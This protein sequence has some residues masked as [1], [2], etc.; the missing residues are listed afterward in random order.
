MVAVSAASGNAAGDEVSLRLP[1]SAGPHAVPNLHNNKWCDY[2]RCNR[3]ACCLA[4][5]PTAPAPTPWAVRGRRPPDWWEVVVAAAAPRV[6]RTEGSE[7]GGSCACV[8]VF[9]LSTA[10]ADRFAWIAVTVPTESVTKL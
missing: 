7:T 6:Y 5:P 3:A 8:C 4:R 10:I 9:E 1:R 2:D